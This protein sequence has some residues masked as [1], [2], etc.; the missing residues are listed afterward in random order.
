MSIHLPQLAYHSQILVPF[1]I[2]NTLELFLLCLPLLLVTFPTYNVLP[3]QLSCPSERISG[4][5]DMYILC[6]IN[7]LLALKG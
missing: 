5:N 6:R 2:Q 4:T 7:Y 1:K 3:T